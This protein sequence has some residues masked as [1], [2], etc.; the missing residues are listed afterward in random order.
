MNTDRCNSGISIPELS[1]DPCHGE[2]KSTECI[3]HKDA[4]TLLDLPPNSTQAEINNAFVLAI[5]S[6]LLR[7]EELEPTL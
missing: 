2:T 5:N 1:A 7:I 4:I 6:L 3:I